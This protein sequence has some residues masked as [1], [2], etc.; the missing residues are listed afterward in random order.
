MYWTSGQKIGGRIAMSI[1]PLIGWQMDQ[2]QHAPSPQDWPANFDSNSLRSFIP[3]SGH[4]FSETTTLPVP[5]TSPS[6]L[7]PGAQNNQLDIIFEP[8]GAGTRPALSTGLA[9]AG[10]SAP[11][12]A[13][14]LLY[15]CTPTASQYPRPPPAQ[16]SQRP[17]EDLPEHGPCIPILHRDPVPSLYS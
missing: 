2:S 16:S 1:V 10:N 6:E 9:G 15:L 4:T 17:R 7:N 13:T 11:W 8:R 3:L 14:Y 5:S 12:T